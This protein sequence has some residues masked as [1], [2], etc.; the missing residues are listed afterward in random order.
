MKQSLLKVTYN[1]SGKRYT[2]EFILFI[3]DN[4]E[5]LLPPYA[6]IVSVELLL[7]VN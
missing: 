5:N 1:F 4:I 6:Q 7:I 2:N 3:G